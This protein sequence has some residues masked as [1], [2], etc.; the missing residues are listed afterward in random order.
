MADITM[1]TGKDCP[2]KESCY[3]YT[4]TPNKFRQSY[5]LQPPVIKDEEV[6]CEMYW[7]DQA[8]ATWKQLKNITDDK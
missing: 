7:G 2:L 3:R 4:A 6:N 1:C 5:F 8:H